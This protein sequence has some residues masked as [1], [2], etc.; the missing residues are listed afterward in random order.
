MFNVIRKAMGLGEETKRH[1]NTA[2]LSA[3]AEALAKFAANG[4]FESKVY[5][6]EPIFI[7]AE[8]K[9]IH[10]K[11]R[12]M[13]KI[14]SHYEPEAK[15]F[16]EQAKFM[17]DFEDDYD[18]RGEFVRYFPTYRSMSDQ[19]L[20]GYFSWRA[21]VRRGVISRT[22]LSFV[23]VYIY[24]LI[25][26]IGVDSPEKGF[27]A[28]KNFWMIYREID[29]K[30]TRYVRMWLKDY[31]VYNNLD[32]SL[33]EGL[34][35]E[36]FDN[37]I[38]TLFNHESR[39][40]DEVFEALNSMS[41]YNI[42]NSRLFKQ[43][44]DDVKNVVRSV[45]SALSDYYGDDRKDE[46][47]EKFFGKFFSGSYT[48]F[49]SAV[50]YNRISRKDYVYEINDLCKYTCKGGNW[51]CE[52]FFCYSGKNRQVGAMMKSIDFFM[53]PKCNF[54]PVKKAEKT[55]EIL[56][57]IISDVIDKYHTN[58][59][60]AARPKIEIDVSKLESI[61][62]A[63]LETQSKLLVEE[64]EEAKAPEILDKKRAE[65]CV[66][67]SD[68]EYLFMKCLLYGE[69]YDYLLRSK[70][71]MLSVM[72]DAINESLF[73]RFG[74][75]VIVETGGRAELVSDYIEELKGIIGE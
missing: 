69:A 14:G 35:D 30:I 6:D 52:R 28:L 32:K 72:V 49:N 64:L 36:K 12:D 23:F 61:R 73:D 51:S 50:F 16:Y 43:Y 57:L 62:S 37:A 11:Y 53:R 55:A 17:E 33:L 71:L 3:D 60:E 15:V 34:F 26:Q 54:K 22:S 56:Q 27:H 39:N 59:E 74:D 38:M 66:G 31:V 20:R 47:R 5:Q 40:A 48:I 67:L 45:Y 4:S 42:V 68:D 9:R 44:P 24:E 19:Q 29:P 65:N 1:E 7:N 46:F 70:G 75:T 10:P 8:Q 58:Q 63:A 41:S 13:R 21:K 25:N 2:L 18:Y